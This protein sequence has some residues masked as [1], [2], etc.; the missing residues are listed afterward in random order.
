MSQIEV[1][2]E[3]LMGQSVALPVSPELSHGFDK[4]RRMSR[5]L[6][7]LLAAGFWVTLAWLIAMAALLVWPQAGSLARAATVI[8]AVGLPFARRAGA[9]VAILLG[10]APS[11]VVLHQAR[12]VFLHF[13]KGEV[14]AP[15]A[16]A[17]IRSAGL[18]LIICTFATA[19]GQVLFNISS[20]LRPAAAGLD[21][22]PLLLVF[23]VA[24]YVAAY[25]V[26]EARR[27]ADDNAAIV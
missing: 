15:A 27:I 12:C 5:V 23:G 17:H 9:I 22:R 3:F 2:H 18:W 14:F 24:T 8:P 26:A 16:I 13:A 11:L 20:A 21:L 1:T 6:A 7:L 10:T 19:A 4:A 25:V